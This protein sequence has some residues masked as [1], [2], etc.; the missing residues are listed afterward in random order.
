MR[1]Q[2][3]GVQGVTQTERPR[4]C[5]RHFPGVLRVDIEIQKV[6]GLICV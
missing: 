3:I 2:R 1:T 4:Q 5:A 6:K